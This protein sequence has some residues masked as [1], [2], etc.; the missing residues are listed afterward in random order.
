MNLKSWWQ[1]N[2]TS[3]EMILL[4]VFVALFL[5]MSIMSPDK[6]L[7]GQNLRSMA[8]QFPELGIIALGMMTVIVTGGIDLSL[9]FAA[10]LAGIAAGFVLASGAAS[11]MEL[12]GFS[13]FWLIVKAVGV[14]LLVGWACGAINGF[15]V[16]R[17]G[18]SPILATI[19]T[20][21]LFEGVGLLF[22]KGGA[23]SGFPSQYQWIGNGSILSI[24]VPIVIFALLALLTAILLER[25]A[26]GRSVYMFGCNSIAT[27]FS[28]INTK[29]VVTWV[30]LYAGTM[31]AMAAL[32]MTSRYNSAKVDYGSSYLLQ[33][34]AAVVLGGTDIAG[35]Y[36]KVMGTMVAIGIVQVISSGLNLLGIN[37][38]IVD[39]TMGAI[40]VGVLLLN[41]FIAQRRQRLISTKKPESQ[42]LAA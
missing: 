23:I 26:W 40:L 41:F 31:A 34:I 33:S 10:A 37:R 6:F 5:F 11:G 13:A 17:I 8:G 19:G 2:K 20:M 35:G 7:S 14:A 28:G 30:Y 38:Y 22:S 12:S 21:T 3:K 1:R 32:I 15:F 39:V 24:P 36:G 29:R 9:T 25:T 42:K 27:L 18:V 4:Y 16:A